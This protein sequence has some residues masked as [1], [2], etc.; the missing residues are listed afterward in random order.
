M[1]VCVCVCVCLYI[2]IY[3]KIFLGTKNQFTLCEPM[4]SFLSLGTDLISGFLELASIATKSSFDKAHH[5][6]NR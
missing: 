2:Y 5:F 6:G 1:C 3:A 4:C